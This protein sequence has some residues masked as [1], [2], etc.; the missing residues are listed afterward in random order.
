MENSAFDFNHPLFLHASDA[1]GFLLVSHQ[2][3]GIENYG[4]WSRSM[5]IA[6]LAKNKLGFVTGD[7][8]REDFDESLHPQ[9]ERCNAL[10]LS[11]ILNTVSKE[12]SA[13]IVFASSAASV[14][15]DLRERFAKVDGSRSF[16]LHREIALLNQGDSSISTYFTRLKS[17]WDE[18]E[19]LAPISPCDCALSQRTIA[20]Y[21]QQKL[22][23]FLMGL[24][25]T[26]TAVRS[27][28]LL[29]KPL[30]TVNMAYSML[31][32]EESQRI[33]SSALS[34]ISEVSALYSTSV[35]NADKKR[36]SGVCDYCKVRG[37]KRENCYRLIGF[38]A[39]FKFSKKK[40]GQVA[41]AS[42]R[43][44]FGSHN[45]T[46]SESQPDTVSSV[47]M[48]TKAQYDQ[49]L[50][51][52][53]KAPSVDTMPAATSNTAGITS[54]TTSLSF[55][56][57]LDSGATDHMLDFQKLVSPVPCTSASRFVYLPNGQTAPIT[58]TG[59]FP[60]DQNNSLKHVLF[61]P[62]FA[63]NHLSVSKL[64]KELNCTVSFYPDFCILQ[65]LSTG[66]MKGIVS[67]NAQFVLL[68]NNLGY[69]FHTVLLE[70]LHLLIWLPS[71]SLAGKSPFELLHVEP[72]TYTEAIQNL[73]WIKAMNEEFLAL[74]SN[75]TWSLVPLPSNKTPIG[76]KWVYRI[77][78]KSNGEVE[79]FK[80]RLV[81][82]GYTQR[83]GVDYVE[84]F[85]PVAKM[86]TVRTVLALASIHQ[87]PLFQMDVYNAFL[88]GDLVEEAS[89]QWNMK[90]TEVLLLAVQVK[91]CAECRKS[92][93]TSSLLIQIG[94][95]PMTRRSVTGSCVKLGD[96]LLSWKSKKQNTI[97]RSSA[98]AEYRSMA[99]TAAEIVWLTGLLNELGFNN[100]GPAKLMWSS[101]KEITL[102]CSFEG[103]HVYQKQ[104]RSR[105]VAECKSQCQLQ[106]FC[107]SDWATCPMTRRSVTGSCVKL[108]DS[109]LSWKS[110][111]Q[112]TIAR[113]SAEAEYRNTL[114]NHLSGHKVRTRTPSIVL[115]HS[116]YFPIDNS[117]PPR[118]NCQ[119]IIFSPEKW[120]E[121]DNSGMFRPEMLLPIGFPEDVRVIAWAFPSK[122]KNRETDYDTLWNHLSGHKVDLGL[123]KR[124]PICGLGIN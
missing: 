48:F 24:N 58:Y 27:Q 63:H 68:L 71:S 44:P 41:L 99:M 56:W 61:I 31:V 21:A 101:T 1:P 88:Q 104:S 28:I 39:N 45:Q 70:L 17:L 108:G 47:P 29:M 16:F 122:G 111:K 25:D 69:L 32:Q 33:H 89:R 105:S 100:T 75:N 77:K 7:C 103:G 92:M 5:K 66:E 91:E 83:E 15:Q 113:S 80:A 59:S 62:D 74:E 90:L 37:H 115:L 35:G 26:Y 112:N 50:H 65:D 54:A 94:N 13:G 123:I 84:T 2:L 117:C 38:P 86:V 79:R 106:A 36:F 121:I 14:W 18:Y 46:S 102:G 52:L 120:V 4:V 72:K 11:W 114:W 110:K 20:H 10:V 78:Y 118:G 96:S 9:W 53:N 57:I 67:L 49:I 12:L 42:T 34:P 23:Q 93:P 119:R 116:G 97:A 64:T 124:N 43:S 98:E 60:L 3:L 76:S 55:N 95:L 109:L 73:E 107:D 22:F 40:A 30:P 85:S 87:W 6:L 19:A 51:L 82:K 8:R 81:A